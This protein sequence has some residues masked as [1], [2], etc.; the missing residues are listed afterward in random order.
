MPQQ[1]SC[2]RWRRKRRTERSS[3]PHR[4]WS[5]TSIPRSTL[6]MASPRT[7]ATN[8]TS[9][10][11]TGGPLLPVC[12]SRTLP[13]TY[14]VGIGHVCV[15]V[16]RRLPV[17]HHVH[18]ESWQFTGAQPHHCLHRE[19]CPGQLET[20]TILQIFRLI[21]FYMIPAYPRTS[22]PPSIAAWATQGYLRCCAEGMAGHG[23]EPV[24]AGGEAPKI[25]AADSPSGAW[26]HR[27]AFPFD[28][29]CNWQAALCAAV[30]CIDCVRSFIDFF[31]WVCHGFRSAHI[32]CSALL[33]HV[34]CA[35]CTL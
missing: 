5:S 4:R 35:P 27:H 26:R 15:L 9:V 29:Q 32:V 18:N 11:R 34:A 20:I 33:A 3:A 12:V 23:G 6:P 13:C 25:R 8:L 14:S 30:P 21:L 19:D 7:S 17:C 28:E 31:G 24:S 22:D 2:A 10:R 1:A 16:R